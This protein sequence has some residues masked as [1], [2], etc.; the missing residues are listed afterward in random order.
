MDGD[1]DQ[2]AEED[3][4][5]VLRASDG[6]F[7]EVRKTSDQTSAEVCSVIER[8]FACSRGRVWWLSVSKVVRRCPESETT[9]CQELSR[10]GVALDDPVLFIPDN[11][12]GGPN[13][14]YSGKASS[15]QELI[16]ECRYWEYYVYAPAAR[17]LVCNT[18]H[19]EYVSALAVQ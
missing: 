7:P 13:P 8:Q 9:L 1:D 19:N 16:A 4:D 3:F 17:C 2:T 15:F 10:L 12:N 5:T 18:D 11:D 6:Q 14:V